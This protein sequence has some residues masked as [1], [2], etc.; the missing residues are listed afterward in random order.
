MFPCNAERRAGARIIVVQQKYR[1]KHALQ[2][3]AKR[4]RSGGDV[5][6]L[7]RKGR[8]PNVPAHEKSC[9]GGTVEAERTDVTAVDCGGAEPCHTGKGESEQGS[10]RGGERVR[11][12]IGCGRRVAAERN[13]TGHDGGHDGGMNSEGNER[14]RVYRLLHILRL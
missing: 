11:G 3:K 4:A 13:E 8:I 6:I 7:R 12:K 1:E 5:E 2:K 10:G 9:W 14:R